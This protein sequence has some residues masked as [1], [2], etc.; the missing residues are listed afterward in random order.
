MLKLNYEVVVIHTQT[1]PYKILAGFKDSDPLELLKKESILFPFAEASVNF[2][3]Q[4]SKNIF[5][6]KQLRNYP[7]FISLAHWL[8]RAH[9]IE[10]KN[11][12]QDQ[13]KDRITLSRGLILHFA[14]A[15]VD[16]LFVYSWLISLLAGNKNIIRISATTEKRTGL[17][18][19]KIRETLEKYPIIASRTLIITYPHDT[20]I[21]KQFS[22]MCDCRVI[23][24]GDH[25]VQTIRSISLP[26][27]ATEIVFPNRFSHA[28]LCSNTF[29]TASAE[30][31]RV[32]IENFAK[33]FLWH[34]QATCS[35]PKNVIWLGSSDRNQEAQTEF[36]Q[37]VNSYLIEKNPK[38][39]EEIKLKQL[40]LAFCLAAHPLVE[41]FTD[42][43]QSPIFNFKI[44]HI[45][46]SLRYLHKGLGIF[47]EMEIRDLRELYAILDSK[48]QTIGSYGVS[49]NEWKELV[50]KL[51]K[52]AIDRIVPFGQMLNFSPVWDGYSL[53]TYFTRELQFFENRQSL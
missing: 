27:H 36:W 24:G 50:T 5:A 48:D 14:P 47:F 2:I 32:L 8:R 13:F 19:K 21:T 12:F 46:Q 30:E 15:N 17:L 43:L 44:K 34:H 37:K 26:P 49:Q 51:P 31:K 20:E 22:M 38:W 16:V 3:A 40:T 11:E 18:L 53:L 6:D 41:K 10:L 9:I 1:K 7:E 29:L 45:D 39:I 28:L 52:R 42:T 4:L 35:S 23:W 33:D 25:T